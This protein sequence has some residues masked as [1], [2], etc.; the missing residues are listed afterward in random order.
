[1]CHTESCALKKKKKSLS[2]A[3]LVEQ[4]SL[5]PC[6]WA[7]RIGAGYDLTGLLNYSSLPV[8]KCCLSAVL[9]LMSDDLTRSV[10]VSGARCASLKLSFRCEILYLASRSTSSAVSLIRMCNTRRPTL[11]VN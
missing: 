2:Y 4:P 1:M 10:D 6:R 5:V 11:S 7:F 3:R 9:V 8:L